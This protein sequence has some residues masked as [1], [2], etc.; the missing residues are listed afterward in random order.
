[1]APFV[2][3]TDARVGPPTSEKAM[4]TKDDL[5]KVYKSEIIIANLI[6]KWEIE[7]K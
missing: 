1:M 6:H 3:A 4:S 2:N 5:N 7:L